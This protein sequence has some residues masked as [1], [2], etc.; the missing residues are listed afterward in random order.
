VAQKLRCHNE[1]QDMYKEHQETGKGRMKGG[2]TPVSDDEI[3][4]DVKAVMICDGCNSIMERRRQGSL[5]R[6]R[7]RQVGVHGICI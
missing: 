6:R 7:H 4:V 1:V 3:D 2:A 5:S